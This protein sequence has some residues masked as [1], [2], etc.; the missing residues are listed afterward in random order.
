MVAR[1]ILSKSVLD[2]FSPWQAIATKPLVLALGVDPYLL[3]MRRYR[4][5]GPPAIP[6]EWIKGHINAYRV[7]DLRRWL[8]DE[9]TDVE[10]FAAAL[11][12]VLEADE[13][14]DPAVIR[15]LARAISEKTPP[16]GFHFTHSGRRA[17]QES[18]TGS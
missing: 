15:L 2:G 10:Q 17:Y 14:E 8:G 1:V 6:A 18:I 16:V 5:L 3:G 9:R 4:G 12:E 13:A 11:G 7:S